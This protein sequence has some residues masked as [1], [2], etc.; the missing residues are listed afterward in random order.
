[1][2][3]QP[4]SQPWASPAVG[5]GRDRL[6]GFRLLRRSVGLVSPAVVSREFL[7]MQKVEDSSPIIRLRESPANAGLSSSPSPPLATDCRQVRSQVRSRIPARRRGRARRRFARSPC[8]S[9]RRRRASSGSG[10]RARRAST[11][12]RRRVLGRRRRA[13]R[14]RTARAICRARAPTSRTISISCRPGAGSNSAPR[15]RTLVRRSRSRAAC[16]STR[17]RRR[18]LGARSAKAGRA[19]GVFGVAVLYEAIGVALRLHRCLGLD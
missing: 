2:V 12:S 8:G 13:A 4:F 18:W 10:W 17:G 9:R 5:S 15:G 16:D 7:A 11:R 3:S 19:G 6:C 1:M 14:S